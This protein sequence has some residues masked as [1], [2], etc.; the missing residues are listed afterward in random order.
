MGRP[1][2]ATTKR[3]RGETLGTR[4]AQE[5]LSTPA[6]AKRPTLSRLT[7]LNRP[8]LARTHVHFILCA[9]VSGQIAITS[10][11]SPRAGPPKTRQSQ[12]QTGAVAII[13]RGDSLWE[14]GYGLADLEQRVQATPTTRY[15]IASISKAITTVLVLQLVEQGALDLDAPIQRYVPAFPAKRYPVTMRA[16]L[17]A[18]SGVRGYQGDE[19]VNDR[20][21]FPTC[22]RLKVPTPAYSSPRGGVRDD[23]MSPAFRFSRSR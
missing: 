8:L 16:L 1:A 18:T 20:L 14:R 12:G 5:T 7:G 22:D 2:L 23:R 21:I 4:H 3:P 11:T 19:S 10:N 6:D 17:A 13:Y 9:R 15:R